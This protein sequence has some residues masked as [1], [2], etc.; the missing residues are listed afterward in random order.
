MKFIEFAQVLLSTLSKVGGD[1]NLFYNFLF[2]AWSYINLEWN[3]T[4]RL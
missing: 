4:G 3:E 2:W 1:F